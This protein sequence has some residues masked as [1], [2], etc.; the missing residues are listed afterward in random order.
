MALWVSFPVLR[1]S[2]V[3]SKDKPHGR[4]VV[5]DRCY[6]P[7]HPGYGAGALL[8]RLGREQQWIALGA[9]GVGGARRLG[10]GDVLGEHGDDADAAAVR[11]DHHLVGLILSHA[12]L[13]LQHRDDEFAR[14]EIVIDQDDLVQSRPLDL[15]LDL[16]L[17]L[18]GGVGHLQSRSDAYAIRP[19]ALNW[20]GRLDQFTGSWPVLKRD[21]P[22]TGAE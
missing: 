16:G 4:K 20:F 8:F 13:G 17:W 6:A 14:R 18:G 10:L 3:S 2:I 15:G 1:Q 11:R 21:E 12:K 5:V 19:A 22:V 7:P 9:A